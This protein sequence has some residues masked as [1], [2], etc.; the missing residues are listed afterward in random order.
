MRIDALTVALRPR[1][2]WEA[3]ELGGALLRAHAG[4][5]WRPWLALTLPL[6]ALLNLALWAV[7][8]LWL[9]APLMWWLKPLFDRVPLY[10]LSRAVFGDV[11]APR[12]TLRALPR[13]ARP[14]L[15]AGLTWRRL[16]PVRS[17]YLPVD[18]LE[19]AD[20]AAARARRG[21]LGGP[22]YGVAA[23]LTLVCVNFEL[24]LMAGL[25]S[26]AFVFIP[27]EHFVDAARGL[28]ELLVAQPPWIQFS[29]NAIAYLATA[30][31]EP[32]FVA[33]GF[34][35]YL[36]R[37]TEIEGWDIELGLRRLRTRLLEQARP[38]ALA[39]LC[40]LAWTAAPVAQAQDAD[41]AARAQRAAER[42]GRATEDLRDGQPA[43]TPDDVFGPER[44]P[45]ADFERAVGEAYAGPALKP[46]RK[47]VRWKERNP[48]KP[49]ESKPPPFLEAIAKAVALVG[50]FVLWGLFA[51]LALVLLLTAR[52]WLPWLRGTL[53]RERPEPAP[54]QHRSIADAAPL[55]D[56]VPTA[57]RALWAQGRARDALALLYRASVAAMV[58]RAQV[59]LAPGATEAQCLRA[60]RQMPRAD[61]RE[62]F[63]EVV[64]RWQLAAYA[65]RLPGADEFDALL[66]RLSERFG[67]A[68]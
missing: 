43:V 63:A 64:R 50:E 54:V 24:A 52:H 61:D 38:L 41:E 36:N 58:E 31:I 33:A 59:V 53:A 13:F 17:L 25:G 67:W 34:G 14:S 39:L 9:A 48:D 3:V 20:A 37:R 45:T 4:A 65:R 44:A 56:D 46:T 12:A 42:A 15:L 18:L 5:V 16:S 68:R 2:A 57:A 19:G 40:A 51:A 6:F 47:V 66:A 10:V 60:S 22:V 23:L 55:P 49:S 27:P 35:L 1:S 29:Y 8:L 28:W 32:F 21:A 26:L 11:P 30:V 62:A 7:D